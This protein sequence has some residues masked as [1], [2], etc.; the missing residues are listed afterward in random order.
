MPLIERIEAA[1]GQFDAL[2]E[3]LECDTFDDRD[4]MTVRKSGQELIHERHLAAKVLRD[5]ATHNL[6][7]EK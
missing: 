3:R 6:G 4:G 5:L 1:E 2:I 7:E